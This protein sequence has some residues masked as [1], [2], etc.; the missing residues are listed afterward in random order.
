MH[1]CKRLMKPALDFLLCIS[2]VLG[3]AW[4]QFSV[5]AEST[6]IDQ[7]AEESAID[8]S[9]RIIAEVSAIQREIDSAET[10]Y[11]PFHIQL[12]EPLQR[13]LSLQIGLENYREVDRLI[14][15]YLQISRIN[16]S[17]S[18]FNQLPA[19]VEQISNDIRLEQWESINDRFQ[20][21][22][23]IFAQHSN[24]DTEDLLSLLDEF[25]AWNLAAVY[26]DIPELRA[27]YFMAYR[28]VIENAVEFAEREYGSGGALFVP[29][30]YRAALMEY[31]GMTMQRTGDELRLGL[32]AGSL[33]DALSAVR[34]IR[35][36]ADQFDNPEATAMA[37]VYEADF[38]K[39]ANDLGR[40]KNYGNSDALYRQAVEKFRE[41][42]LDEEKIRLFPAANNTADEAILHVDRFGDARA[43]A[44]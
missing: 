25:A 17:L 41:G 4:V 13:M 12:L 43:A 20:F 16:Q 31:R 15:R 29:W 30:L 22:T 14:D 11:G 10:V 26:I 7:Q 3:V 27:D 36:I 2:A 34:R 37:M 23:W 33:D 39:L 1:D 5:A 6:I 44:N 40:N 21:M 8:V 19:L 32:K 35:P 9:N 24:Y 18:S 38:I 28:A 42:G